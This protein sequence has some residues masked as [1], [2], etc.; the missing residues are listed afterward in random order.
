MSE[1][2]ESLQE[3][4]EALPTSG[5]LDHRGNDACSL[6]WPHLSEIDS[7]L[8]LIVRHESPLASS[9]LNA[10]NT[11]EGSLPLPPG[12]GPMFL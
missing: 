10:S 4:K 8:S 6:W 2:D 12:L 9:L 7:L 3:S 1:P 5:I 11:G